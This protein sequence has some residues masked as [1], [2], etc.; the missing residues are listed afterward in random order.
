MNFTKLIILTALYSTSSAHAFCSPLPTLYSAEVI[1]KNLISCFD[2]KINNSKAKLVPASPSTVTFTGSQLLFANDRPIPGNTRSAVFSID[3]PFKK[4][5]PLNFSSNT[6]TY[7]TDHPFKQARKYESSTLTPDGKYIILAT[8]FST[9]GHVPLSDHPYN[10]MLV[11]PT[12]SPEKVK[13]VSP[14]TYNG[15]TSS[16][17]L[18]NQIGYALRTEKHPNGPPY[19]NTEG[20]AAIPGNQLLFGIRQV[21]IDYDNFE[22]VI[23]IL[24]ASY[25]IIDGQ[26]Y[27]S[28]DF[29]LAYEVDLKELTNINHPLGLSSLEYDQ[30]N[31]R[32]YLLTTCERESSPPCSYLWILPLDDFNNNRP[33]HLVY[34]KDGNPLC[35][36]NKMEG[37]A[38]INSNTIF[39]VADDDH[40]KDSLP[41]HDTNKAAYA[42]VRITN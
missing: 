3:F 5:H 8:G 26:L 21:G 23:K 7:H 24:K 42:I 39:I 9:A 20:L 15:V 36:S 31:N 34:D 32:L 10:T 37:L 14:N 22:F 19:H 40:K 18:K 1:E 11:F 27:V 16:L 30:Y 25:E 17:P 4:N 13:V 2:H 29:T 33:P 28:D 35:F 6:I 38:V 41:I 12:N